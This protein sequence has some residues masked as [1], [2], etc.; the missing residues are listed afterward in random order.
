MSHTI[1]LSKAQGE[2]LESMPQQ[3][4]ISVM[5]SL[6]ANL[7]R[8]NKGELKDPNMTDDPIML[9]AEVSAMI[10]LQAILQKAGGEKPDASK[11]N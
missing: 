3:I 9:V 7:I 2:M 4:A 1:E 10:T 8:A 11:V 5:I 6:A